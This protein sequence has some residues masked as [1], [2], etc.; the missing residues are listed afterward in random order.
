VAEGTRI[1]RRKRGEG[2]E[3]RK[4]NFFFSFTTW[5]KS[6]EI[7]PYGIIKLD[8]KNAPIFQSHVVS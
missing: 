4:R 5:K 6:E 7:I 1:E 8:S 2:G 3:K